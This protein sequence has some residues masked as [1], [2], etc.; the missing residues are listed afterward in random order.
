MELSNK[1][2]GSSLSTKSSSLSEVALD[3]LIAEIE[4]RGFW[5]SLERNK[6]GQNK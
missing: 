3:D 6:P 1:K 4:K 5:V 2:S